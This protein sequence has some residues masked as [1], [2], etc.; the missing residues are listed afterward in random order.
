M[1][2]RPSVVQVLICDVYAVMF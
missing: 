1:Y 2:F